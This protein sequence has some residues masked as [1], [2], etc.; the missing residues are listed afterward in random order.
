MGTHSTG[1]A[2]LPFEPCH[3][4]RRRNGELR[5]SLWSAS[6]SYASS[7]PL[8]RWTCQRQHGKM[9]AE[10]VRTDQQGRV[11]SFD[12]PALG[13]VSAYV[14]FHPLK[15]ESQWCRRKAE[16]GECAQTESV[17]C[18][19]IFC[20]AFRASQRDWFASLLMQLHSR[21]LK[22]L[23]VWFMYLLKRARGMQVVH[24]SQA[25]R[26]RWT[27]ASPRMQAH[28]MLKAQKS[29]C[30]YFAFPKDLIIKTI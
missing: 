16:S 7:L 19:A 11:R 29:K 2:N 14:R 18:W 28:Y 17:G 26:D 8:P 10:F 3:H 23:F 9:P 21:S 30:F 6:Y 5:R 22:A 1:T 12:A 20:S 25:Q 24:R 13:C 4:G 15:M 27:G